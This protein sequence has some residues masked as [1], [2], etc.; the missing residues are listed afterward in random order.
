MKR[1]RQYQ[2]LMQLSSESEKGQA[3][4]ATKHDHLNFTWIVNYQEQ[5]DK[6]SEVS[7]ELIIISILYINKTLLK[8]YAYVINKYTTI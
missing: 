1:R 6:V 2:N 8:N 3:K 5:T 4:E 7:K